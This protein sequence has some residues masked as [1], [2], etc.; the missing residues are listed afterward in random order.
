MTPEMTQKLRKSLINHE[1]YRTHPY[2]DTLGKITIGI[3]YNLTDR[4]IDDDWISAQ[5]QKDVTYFYSQLSTFPWFLELTDDR[6]I[7][8]IDMC[9]MGWKHFLSFKEMFIALANHDY[10]KAAKEML[11]S[12][13][14]EQVKSR[15]KTLAN[16]MRTGIYQL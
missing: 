14:A 15:A 8:L 9:F 2:K 7:A 12:K 3:G 13:W 1:D 6:Q 5:Y 11:D 10:T 16:V 4:G